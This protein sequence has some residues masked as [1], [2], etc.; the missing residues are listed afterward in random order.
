MVSAGGKFTGTVY[1]VSKDRELLKFDLER[2]G[3]V[4]V[5]LEAG[6]FFDSIDYAVANVRCVNCGCTGKIHLH[7][8]T[9]LCDDWSLPWDEDMVEYNAEHECR[10]CG[11][12]VKVRLLVQWYNNHVRFIEG[13][14][15]NSRLLRLAK[16]DE[17]DEN[18]IR[19]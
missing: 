5:P 8:G 13:K 15:L 2:N 11:M 10:H 14:L 4:C 1:L 18:E 17:M 9:C 12:P 3:C 6:E 19:I 16:V 7:E